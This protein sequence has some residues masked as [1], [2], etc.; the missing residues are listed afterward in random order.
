VPGELDSIFNAILA[1]ELNLAESK[2]SQLEKAH[3]RDPAAPTKSSK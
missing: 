1:G 3:P 2:L